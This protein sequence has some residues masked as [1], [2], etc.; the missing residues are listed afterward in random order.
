MS[1]RAALLD[2]YSELGMN[3]IVIFVAC[4]FGIFSI[5]SLLKD[6]HGLK[7][8]GLTIVHWS[9]WLGGA[10]SLA[11]YN[12]YFQVSNYIL[13][14]LGAYRGARLSNETNELV[15]YERYALE[16]PDISPQIRW[17]FIV[18]ISTSYIFYLSLINFDSTVGFFGTV[19][20]HSW[21]NWMV[22]AR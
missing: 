12:F 13:Q 16:D 5:L 11:K 2:Y 6:Y 18:G 14:D 17:F 10:Y 22:I 1:D 7:F 3:H 15:T 4:I 9:L 20:W 21:L 19:I 8:L